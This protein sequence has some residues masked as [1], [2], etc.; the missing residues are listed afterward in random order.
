M[1]TSSSPFARSFAV[2]ILASVAAGSA[3]ADPPEGK[4]KGKGHESRYEDDASRQGA[5]RPPP[6]REDAR[7]QLAPGQGAYFA[8]QHRVHVHE[9]YAQEQRR[10]FCPPG[11][12]KRN[13][14][15][16]PPG[17]A[18]KWQIGRPL[19]RDVVFYDLP[20][21]LVTQIGAPPS[22]YRYVR[23]AADILLIAIGTGIV[24]DAIQDLGRP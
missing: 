5:R 21:Q 8:D 9:Y 10:G 22:G 24:I 2:L 1:T 23:T 15:C 17:Q 14:G 7:R 18:R 16:L 11:L 12:A 19:A 3:L 20:P 13:N 6:P 4:G